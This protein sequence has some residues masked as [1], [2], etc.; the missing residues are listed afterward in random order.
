M[1][2]YEGQGKSIQVAPFEKHERIQVNLIRKAR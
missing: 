2:I 1:R